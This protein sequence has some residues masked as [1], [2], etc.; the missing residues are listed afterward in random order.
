MMIVLS[1][2]KIRQNI[3]QVIVGKGAVID[4]VMTALIAEG[5]VLLDDVPGLGKTLLAKAFSRSLDC[6]FKRIQFT[7]D[8]QPT[9][10]IGIN[11]YNQKTEEFVFKP[12]P[13]MS[14]VILADEINRAVPRTQSAL[15][16]VMEEK[17]VTVDGITHYLREPF[18]VIATQNPLEFE[19]TFNLPEAQLDRFLIKAQMGYPV[20]DEEVEVLRR[21]KSL[22]PLDELDPVITTDE[23]IQLRQMAKEV[24]VA[25]ELFSYIHRLILATREHQTIRLG[26][27]PR[28]ALA[29]LKASAAY[30]LIKGRSYVLPDDI[31]YLFPFV[32]KHR[33]LLT[34]EA[35]LRGVSKDEIIIEIIQKT[36]VPVEGDW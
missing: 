13:I 28:G 1:M 16:E 31:K 10:I 23:I 22:N 7:P 3:Q 15:L 29:L 33:L 14:N 18:I 34:D 21:F 26:A 17:Q 20:G 6:S 24:Y 2:E 36:S 12:G 5:H 9:D 32:V 11:F 27:S 19:G 8:L 30:A 25:D 4:L 35:D